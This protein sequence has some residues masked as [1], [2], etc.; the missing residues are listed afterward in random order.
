MIHNASSL[1]F[2][3]NAGLFPTVLLLLL[4][5]AGAEGAAPWYFL[6]TFG[7]DV[8]WVQGFADG[9]FATARTPPP[10]PPQ[11]RFLLFADSGLTAA[12]RR[13]VHWHEVEF[14]HGDFMRIMPGRDVFGWYV[15]AFD[16]PKWLSGL[17]V[18]MDLGVIDDADET[19]VN[20]TF[21]GSTGRV[22][23]GSVWQKDRRYRVPAELLLESG[24]GGTPAVLPS[25][26]RDARVTSM[27]AGGTHA[28][29]WGNTV[30]VHVWSL[31]GL[32][33][34]VGPPVLKAAAVPADA[35]W[36]VATVRGPFSPRGLNA[37]RTADEALAICFDGKTI[38]WR[39]AAVPWKDWNSL[40]DDV[41]T[42]AFR[43]RLG[44]IYE[45]G[46]RRDPGG[47]FV[48]DCGPVFDVAAFYLNG[49]RLGLVGR[50][51]EGG[52]PA[53]TEA[54]QR[55]R[56][57][58]EPRDRAA[59]GR[60]ELTVVVFRER[61]VGG[62]PGT[63]GVLLDN[64]LETID[65]KDA[66][67]VSEAFTLLVQSGRFAEAG[68]LLE[69]AVPADGAGRAWLLSHKAHLA[70]LRWLDGG[71]KDAALLDGVLSPIA[72]TL[73]E[74]PVE[75][76]KQSAMQ[77]FCRVLRLAETDPS[78]MAM[79]KRRFPKFGDGCIALPADLSTRGDW[80]ASYGSESHILAAMGQTRDL[81]PL[82]PGRPFNYRLSVP[83]DRDKACRW[84][85]KRQCDIADADALSA[86]DG[87]E[88]TR[89]LRKYCPNLPDTKEDALRHASARGRT[90]SWW[91]DHGEMHP[92]DDN[93]PDLL[94]ELDAADAFPGAASAGPRILTF[95]HVDFDWRD[96]LHPRQQSLLLSDAD[97]NLLNAAWGGK[98][99]HGVYSPFV[100]DADRPLKARFMKHR[101]ACVAVGGVFAD[102]F[103]DYA[104]CDTTAFRRLFAALP[105]GLSQEAMRLLESPAGVA[106]VEIA[107]RILAGGGGVSPSS[108]NGGTPMAPPSRRRDAR[109]TSTVATCVLLAL[110]ADAG[111]VAFDGGNAVAAFARL[112]S[113]LEA[114]EL[115]RL[116]EVI[117]NP[118]L[119]RMR[120]SYIAADRLFGRLEALPMADRARYLGR[121]AVHC[122]GHARRPLRRA[123]LGF[124]EKYAP[125]ATAEHERLVR[126]LP[127]HTTRMTVSIEPPEKTR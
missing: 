114:E 123:T 64:P 10:L 78:V 60:D 121:F 59:D 93:G 33:G 89:S 95:L 87:L 125:Q 47:P 101:G 44:L 96:T 71:M 99:D 77:A 111:V 109:G 2:R 17:D 116:L 35:Q 23:G 19:F 81:H 16:I 31:W 119:F 90:A 72:E 84:L 124:L 63:P 15:H 55:A 40:P 127:E 100:V 4:L 79:V 20:G 45:E 39:K 11:T 58:V 107:R 48:L 97:G 30:A 94:L 57:I 98:S 7:H 38:E 18:V 26:G 110:C 88:M 117:G 105:A 37:A 108:A 1:P 51:P 69:N 70:Y 49:R 8:R 126:S 41:R 27:A 112:C 103:A 73:S 86:P 106:R 118:S 46:T 83:G 43:L 24:N 50:F 76:P 12:E 53:F 67:S 68:N 5:Q 52:E 14:P 3:K 91:D 34:I 82:L 22:P 102:R 74:L 104:S 80:A 85:P 62:L 92:F 28:A 21:V 36:D 66:A 29:P 25:R 54:A 56:F 75:A 113:T 42:M 61:G 13:L 6:P 122:T 65:L 120:W 32:G 9:Y 115:D